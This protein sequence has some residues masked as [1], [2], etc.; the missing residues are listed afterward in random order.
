MR[1]EGDNACE[2]AQSQ[3]TALNHVLIFRACHY[4]LAQ[5]QM[6]GPHHHHAS[7]PQ[8]V[9]AILIQYF[10]VR[11]IF[12]CPFLVSGIWRQ[13]F[14]DLLIK[15]S[16]VLGG[17]K[18]NYCSSPNSRQLRSKKHQRALLLPSSVSL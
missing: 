10:H 12:L 15:E 4:S 14:S 18:L 1:M 5:S 2:T 16:L 7:S 8:Q 13:Q 17:S 3:M 9:P 11:A 6:C